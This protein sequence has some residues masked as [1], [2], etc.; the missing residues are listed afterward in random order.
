MNDRKQLIENIIESVY[1]IR[2]KI[3][4]EMHLFFT[5]A[6]I[7]HSQW[8]MLHIIEKKGALSIKELASLLGTTSSAATQLVDSLVNKGLAARKRNPCDRRVLI[9]ELTA[10]AKKQFESIKNKSFDT[11]AS[12]F[13][14]LDDDELL[15]YFEIN[16]KII[17]NISK[18]M[19]RKKE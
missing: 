12:L 17:T 2:K 15:K 11:M 16:N 6:K 19:P 9:I 18:G 1:A 4:A 7:T 3:I 8:L 14:A 10:Q 13:D 5:E